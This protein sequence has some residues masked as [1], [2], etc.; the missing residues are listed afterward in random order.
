M[1]KNNFLITTEFEGDSKFETEKKGVNNILVVFD[2]SKSSEQAVQYGINLAQRYESVIHL[3]YLA[4]PDDMPVKFDELVNSCEAES[5]LEE[6]DQKSPTDAVEQVNAA[7]VAVEKAL[8]R[9]DLATT[10]IEYTET[11][12]IDLIVLGRHERSRLKQFLRR[13]VDEQ[14]SQTATVPV[15]TVPEQSGTLRT[16]YG[17]ILLATDGYKG[18]RRATDM[19]FELAETYCATLRGV[20]VIASRNK[21]SPIRSVFERRWKKTKRQLNVRAVQTGV[22]FLGEQRV[23]KPSDE[24]LSAA[25]EYDIDIVV[26]G[27]RSQTRLERFLMGSVTSSVLRNASVPVLTVRT[28]TEE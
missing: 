5:S 1:I 18:S 19:A 20:Y 17:T 25:D 14:I 2:G 23:G 16:E 10:V 15:L 28:L 12:S 21:W 7:G 24:I 6:V 11:K 4:D 13:S 22:N 9:G 27:I 3:G 8:L 26:M